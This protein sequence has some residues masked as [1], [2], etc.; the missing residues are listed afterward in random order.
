MENIKKTKSNTQKTSSAKIIPLHGFPAEH[1][2]ETKKL[3]DGI[4]SISHSALWLNKHFSLK[5]KKHLKE[6]IAEHFCNGKSPERNFKELTELIC[7]LKRHAIQDKP[8]GWLGIEHPLGIESIDDCLEKLRAAVP[9]HNKGI[10]TFTTGVLRFMESRNS[11]TYYKYRMLLLT[12]KHEDLL[13]L[14]NNVIIHLH[15]NL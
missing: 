2:P 14:F 9:D 1:S 13:Q 11:S 15:F 8:P 10:W 7:L 6:L 5:E 3:I 4:W 12:Q